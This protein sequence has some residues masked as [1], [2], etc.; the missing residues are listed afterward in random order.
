MRL[1]R[2]IEGLKKVSRTAFHPKPSGW[3]GVPGKHRQW[4][5]LVRE[6]TR[7]PGATGETEAL[8]SHWQHWHFLAASTS[9]KEESSRA[10]APSSAMLRLLGRKGDLFFWPGCALLFPR[11]VQLWQPGEGYPLGWHLLDRGHWKRLC[12]D[13]EPV[14]LP[15]LGEGQ[16]L[17][18][19]SFSRV[20]R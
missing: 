5:E 11:C 6:A 8:E 17:G 15:Q 7:V 20:T 4:R 10:G 19:G 18:W 1:E 9:Q 12:G 2:L 13:R 3:A 16:G 14:P